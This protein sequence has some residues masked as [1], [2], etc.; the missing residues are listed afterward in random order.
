MGAKIANRAAEE[1]LKPHVVCMRGDICNRDCNLK[2]FV[3][4]VRYFYTQEIRQYPEYTRS[5]V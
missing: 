1:F 5:I 2:K 3:V 4:K